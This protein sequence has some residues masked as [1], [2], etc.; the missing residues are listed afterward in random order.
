MNPFSRQLLKASVW[1]IVEHSCFPPLGHGG[2]MSCIQP[3]KPER[4]IC[5]VCLLLKML[6]LC[7]SPYP[8]A[9]ALRFDSSR[10]RR[11]FVCGRRQSSYVRSM[12]DHH[13]DP[14]FGNSHK[15]RRIS[16]QRV[17]GETHR[18]HCFWGGSA[19]FPTERET[20]WRWLPES[21][22]Y[23]YLTLSQ[24]AILAICA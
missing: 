15:L 7:L 14:R 21:I 19:A 1:C 12:D 6:S 10:L 17:S 22:A 2:Q 16:R 5:L 23:M 13:L 4:S 8:P 20:P 3:R 24:R 9:H 18:V 11:W